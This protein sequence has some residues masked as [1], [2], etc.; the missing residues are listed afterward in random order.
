[1]AGKVHG[2]FFVNK[3]PGLCAI[4]HGVLVRVVVALVIQ[5]LFVCGGW[6]RTA[7]Q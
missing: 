7:W 4:E 5:Q 3:A 2:T 1:M 6:S